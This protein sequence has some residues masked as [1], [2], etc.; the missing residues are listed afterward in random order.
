MFNFDWWVQVMRDQSFCLPSLPYCLF[1]QV[2][3]TFEVTGQVMK[4]IS[5]GK[6]DLPV[7]CVN[8]VDNSFP[9]YIEYSTRRLPQNGVNMHFSSMLF[10]IWQ[11]LGESDYRSWLPGGMRLPG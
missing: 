7:S 3:Q 10:C 5:Y 6:E 8:S 11:S 1:F 9:E 4:D 2:L